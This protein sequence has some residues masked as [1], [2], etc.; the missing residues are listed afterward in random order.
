MLS[1]T[2]KE[3]EDIYYNNTNIKACEI[4][5]VSNVTLLKYVRN[6]GIPLKGAG[7]TFR[8]INVVD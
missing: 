7:V 1:L 4:L 2:K 8:K 3:L 6:A 5:K